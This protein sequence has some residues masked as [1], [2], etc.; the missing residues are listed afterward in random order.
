MKTKCP[1]QLKH[2]PKKE[3]HQYAPRFEIKPHLKT[4]TKSWKPINTPKMYKP[5][6]TK[7]QPQRIFMLEEIP[8]RLQSLH[9]DTLALSPNK[10]NWVKS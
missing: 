8:K 7:V 4:V 2:L 3:D 5:F 10:V 6:V 9:F 1:M